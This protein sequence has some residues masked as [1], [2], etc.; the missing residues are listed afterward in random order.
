MAA[1]T[2]SGIKKNIW[3]APLLNACNL[4]GVAILAPPFPWARD[5]WSLCPPLSAGLYIH[6]RYT[7]VYICLCPLS[8]YAYQQSAVY[9]RLMAVHGILCLRHSLYPLGTLLPSYIRLHYHAIA[10]QY[11]AIYIPSIWTVKTMDHM[12]Q[13]IRYS[14]GRNSAKIS[15][16]NILKHY[17]MLFYIRRMCCKICDIRIY[18]IRTVVFCNRYWNACSKKS[19]P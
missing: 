19:Q 5:N 18:H 15:S 10:W 12:L 6:C 7:Y 4:M 11:M 14:N 3:N 1:L 8:L 2:E 13:G 16:R 9:M 17:A